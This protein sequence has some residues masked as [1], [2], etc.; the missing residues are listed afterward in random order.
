MRETERTEIEKFHFRRY[1]QSVYFTQYYP[2]PFC[3]RIV[4]L[5]LYGRRS[6]KGDCSIHKMRIFTQIQSEILDDF[7]CCLPPPPPP[8]SS[9]EGVDKNGDDGERFIFGELRAHMLFYALRVR[10]FH[11]D[12]K[13]GEVRVKWPNLS[14]RDDVTQ[15][16]ST[17]CFSISSAS[18]NIC[19]LR[20]WVV[21]RDEKCNRLIL[22]EGWKKRLGYFEESDVLTVWR[23]KNK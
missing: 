10:R 16:G 18:R 13:V 2:C 23:M 12:R 4:E 5:K 17:T 11:L 3:Y 15:I 22:L 21:Q 19:K 14:R 1:P 9:E 7:A 20:V 6:N 8:P